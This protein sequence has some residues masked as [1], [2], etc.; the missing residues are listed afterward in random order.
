[1][2]GEEEKTYWIPLQLTQTKVQKV[3]HTYCGPCKDSH[4]R[5]QWAIQMD[6]WLQQM[7][8]RMIS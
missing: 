5:Q 7:N 2:K 3:E 6:H 1:M 8:V 4:V